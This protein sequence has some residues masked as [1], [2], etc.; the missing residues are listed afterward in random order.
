[1]YLQTILFAIVYFV[2]SLGSTL[3][4]TEGVMVLGLFSVWNYV[5]NLKTVQKKPFF[6]IG[7]FLGVLFNFKITSVVLFFPL[8][9]NA[10]YEHFKNKGKMVDL[11]K[12]ISCGIA[13]FV[14]I[15]IPFVFYLIKN[16]CYFDFLKYYK[17]ATSGKCFSL[18]E[19]FIALLCL[20]IALFLKKKNEDDGNTLLCLSTFLLYFSVGEKFS[21]YMAAYVCVL[22][23]GLFP[24][25]GNK[26]FHILGLGIVFAICSLNIVSYTKLCKDNQQICQ[27]EVAMQYEIDNSNILYIFEDIGYGCYKDASFVENYQ[28]IPDRYYY[29]DEFMEEYV[30]LTIER[31]E[32][33]QFRYVYIFS[34]EKYQIVNK[35]G[36][37]ME[38]I[39]SNGTSIEKLNLNKIKIAFLIQ[40]IL[41]E[42]YKPISQDSDLY[43]LKD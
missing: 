26:L 16:E 32:T 41:F 20:T 5:K 15:N 4:N 25:K 27:K 9:L 2:A 13:G 11:I 39:E 18:V 10:C 17:F 6:F 22:M 30:P 29:S 34:P 3:L 1:M 24:K 35:F 28:W 8:F 12:C 38:E 21:Y 19:F 33:K 23:M 36:K 40:D 37:T 7:I 31:L 43:V 14:F 42:N